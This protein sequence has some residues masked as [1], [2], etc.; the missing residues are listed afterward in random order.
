MAVNKKSAAF[1]FY[2]KSA[3]AEIAEW[4]RKLNS[5]LEDYRLVSVE[6]MKEALN[7]IGDEALR[8]TPVDSGNLRQSQY[9]VYEI[10][11]N[12]I[13][14][15]IGYDAG[16]GMP[17]GKVIRPSTASAPYA[18]FVHEILRYQHDNPTQA[19]F[20]SSAFSAK[21]SE[22][23]EALKNSLLKHKRRNK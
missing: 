18:A 4:T 21:W 13:I 15:I 1:K 20:L 11:D 14:G 9:R 5:S 10:Y 12:K 7:I 22:A 2:N 19:K 8:L 3:N 23:M 17:K 6:G 16:E